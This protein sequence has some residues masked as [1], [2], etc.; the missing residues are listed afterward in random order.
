MNLL[1]KENWFV[2]LLLMIITQGYF[3][4]I[5][6]YYLKVYDKK[7]WYAKWQYWTCAAAFC[8]FPL[9]FMALVFIIQTACNV[10]LKLNVPGKDVYMNPYIWLLCLVVPIIGWSILIVMLLHVTFYPVVMIYYGEGEK[11][12]SKA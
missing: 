10:C 7:A 1:K 8:I 3:N 2:D 5:F 9:V 4:L 6:G 11:Y 12:I